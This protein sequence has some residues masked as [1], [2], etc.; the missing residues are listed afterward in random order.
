MTML[1]SIRLDDLLYASHQTITQEFKQF[2]RDFASLT[3]VE[4][5]IRLTHRGNFL[6]AFGQANT[7]VTLTCHRC[8]QHFNHRLCIQFDEIF[9]IEDAP[10]DLPREVELDPDDL[11]ERISPKGEFDAEDWVYQNLYLEL[12][13]QLA[14]R[15]DCQGVEVERDTTPSLDPRWAVLRSLQQQV[16]DPLQN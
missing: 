12:P 9:W 14:C 10:T 6:E 7:I 1:R 13:T 3:P 16:S 11:A 15:S 4:G 8:L 5:S 2:F